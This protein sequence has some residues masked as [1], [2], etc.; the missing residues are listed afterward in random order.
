[1]KNDLA[2][3]E[4]IVSRAIDRGAD[5]AEVFFRTARSL[6]IEVRDQMLES[7]KSSRTFGYGLRV[8]R[9]G[10]LGFSYSTGI[11]DSASVI[12]NALDSALNTDQ[13]GYLDLPG[14]SDAADV[15]VFDPLIDQILEEDAIA[16][17]MGIERAAFNTDSRIR[18]VRR[19]SSTFTT[20]DQVIVNS[21][22]V[23]AHYSSTA[24]S[25][26]IMAVAEDRGDTQSGSD[27]S[28]NRFMS[29]VIF[30]DVGR[31]AAENAL[32]LLGS[33]RMVEGRMPVI[34]DS[35]VSTDFL[36]VLAG[37]LSAESVQKGRSLFSEKLGEKVTSPIIN[38]TDNGLL[39]GMLG[40]SPVDDEGVPVKR[41]IM[42]DNGVLRSFLHNTRTAR[43][44]SVASTGN[45]SRGGFSSLPHVGITNL[46]I[47]AAPGTDAVT[48]DKMYGLIGRGLHIFDAMGIHTA[49]PVSGDFSIGVTGVLI[50]DGRVKYPVREAVISGN[51]LELFDKIEA[52]G[53]DLRFYGNIGAP[54]LIISDIAISA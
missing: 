25:A 46:Y 53:D 9:D 19:A 18:K 45:A 20:S 10:C 24:C 47:E 21:K 14:P 5:Q 38:I 42:T 26:R 17:T 34:L 54:S 32:R 28:G 30:E 29:N 27:Y 7:F 39:P 8:I 23:K 37:S 33:K 16:M 31:N 43:K 52:V 40:S 36:G 51:I 22:S 2:L 41:K 6:N 1:M 15:A 12:K 4:D 13:D 35:S 44:G 50:E 49:N 3:A 11:D 48:K